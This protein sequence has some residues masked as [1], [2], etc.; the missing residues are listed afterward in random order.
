M[1][2]VANAPARAKIALKD[3]E[4]ELAKLWDD[5]ASRAR[6]ARVELFTLVALVSDPSLLERAKGVLAGVARVH[7]CRTIAAVWRPGDAASIGAEVELHR[8]PDRKNEACGDG[9]VVEAVGEARD[10]LPGNIDRLLLAD[11]PACVWWVGDL[12]DADDLFDRMV[13]RADVV[14]VNSAEMDLRDLEKLSQIVRATQGGSSFMDLTW[15]RLRGMQD[16]VARFFDDPHARPYLDSLTD[17]TFAYSPRA[18]ETDVASTRAGLLLGWMGSALGF[19]PDTAQWRREPTGG[20]LVISREAGA[21]VKVRFVHDKR[22]GVHDG[23]ITR[24][25]LVC[26]AGDGNRARFELAR[27]EDPTIMRWS[28]DMPGVSTPTQ[29]LKFASHDEGQLLTRSLERP[30][31]DRLL[32][33][34]LR[35]G[36][37]IVR[38][39]APRLSERPPRIV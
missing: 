28:S 2:D 22:A 32:E 21:Q 4:R 11:L 39:V 37:A 33:A 26:D 14:L 12:P 35:V 30:T 1:S 9:I 18:G 15:V 7:D 36:S 19:V 38:P 31:R 34:S 6:S 29:L 8:D 20:E 24:I 13:R 5:E 27:Q 25:E 23:S 17:V 3:V 16:L 10:W